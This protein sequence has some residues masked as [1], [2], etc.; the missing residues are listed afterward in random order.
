MVVGVNIPPCKDGETVDTSDDSWTLRG[1][2]TGTQQR[3]MRPCQRCHFHHGWTRSVLHLTSMVDCLEVEGTRASLGKLQS[4]VPFDE[5][6]FLGPRS[7]SSFFVAFKNVPWLMVQPQILYLLYQWN[8]LCLCKQKL[9]LMC[10]F[11]LKIGIFVAKS[12]K[13]RLLASTSICASAILSFQLN[14]LVHRTCKGWVYCQVFIQQAKGWVAFAERLPAPGGGLRGQA[15]CRASSS[16]IHRFSNLNTTTSRT[17]IKKITFL[18]SAA[19]H[20]S[21]YAF[22][23]QKLSIW[24]VITS[25]I[26]NIQSS[27]IAHFWALMKHE[28]KYTKPCLINLSKF[29]L[30]TNKCSI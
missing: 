26:F 6:V 28:S 21:R 2:R 29:Y 11:T 25:S 8:F 15:L 7:P 23:N 3:W 10:R 22:F 27:Y 1:G 9:L 18:C 24:Y 30:A 4:W 16:K 17:C 5:I 14:I 19:S 20:K 12:H 13:I